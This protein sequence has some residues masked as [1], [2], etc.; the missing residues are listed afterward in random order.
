MSPASWSLLAWLAA[1]SPSVRFAANSHGATVARTCFVA[2]PTL[3]SNS[4][5]IAASTSR[6][7]DSATVRTLPLASARFRGRLS[8]LTYP[9]AAVSDRARMSSARLSRNPERKIATKNEAPA[10]PTVE[11]TTSLISSSS[12][13]AAAS[14]LK[15]EATLVGDVD[16]PVVFRTMDDTEGRGTSLAF[17]ASI[18]AATS[19]PSSPDASSSTSTFTSTSTSTSTAT[20]SF[21]T[22]S[23]PAA[24]ISTTA[25]S[26]TTSLSSISTSSLRSVSAGSNPR[27]RT[28]SSYA[29]SCLSLLRAS[30][31]VCSAS[32][33]LSSVS[34][35]PST[36]AL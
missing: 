13:T 36:C 8:T 25:A 10:A 21:S 30:Q 15:P 5:S 9:T 19:A 31:P 22:P 35:C 24:T 17:V 6:R 4:A 23:F 32:A 20:R 34:A 3:S 29:N 7:K 14:W 2:A 11:Y 18:S 1:T 26:S 28:A 27:N 33:A 12:N 16:P